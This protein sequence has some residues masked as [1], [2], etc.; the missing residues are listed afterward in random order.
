MTDRESLEQLLMDTELLD[1]LEAR[2]SGFNMFETLGLVNAEI[3]HSN[4]L[5]WLMSP[6]ENHGLDDVFLKVS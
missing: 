3:R 2:V 4:M 1:R 6:K 5:A